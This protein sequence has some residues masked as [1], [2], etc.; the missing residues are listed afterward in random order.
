VP[1]ADLPL[2]LQ[3]HDAVS[4]RFCP[5][6]AWDVKMHVASE[7]GMDPVETNQ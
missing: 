2:D 3:V 1:Q 7:S 5:L 4:A 6:S